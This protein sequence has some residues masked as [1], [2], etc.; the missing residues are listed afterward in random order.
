MDLHW[1]SASAQ[2]S[3]I[4]SARLRFGVAMGS[5]AHRPARERS[6]GRSRK[7]GSL[8]ALPLATSVSGFDVAKATILRTLRAQHPDQRVA[9]GASLRLLPRV[10]FSRA[11][12]SFLLRLRVG[13]Y[14][15][16]ARTHRLQG[17]GDPACSNCADTETLDHL[18]LRCPAFDVERTDLC[19]V[20]RRLGLTY[21]T[22]TALLF[23]AAHSSIVKHAL[24]ALLD[25]CNATHLRARL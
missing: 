16:A 24:S 19:T 22:A 2:S 23:P 15:T 10:G 3:A 4:S 20:Y 9:A 17:I 18:L 12:R 21:D 11:D 1:C 5:S 7:A 13:C 25:Y 6:R 14:R 8:P